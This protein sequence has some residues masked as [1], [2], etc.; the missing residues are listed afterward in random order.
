M[1]RILPCGVFLQDLRRQLIQLPEFFADLQL[2]ADALSGGSAQLL[3]R[4]CILV[5]KTAKRVSI[6]ENLLR[7][8]AQY[9]VF[10]KSAGKAAV[11][12]FFVGEG[13]RLFET[14]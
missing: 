7:C 5:M 14:A 3:I 4:R 6:S 12:A 10:P 1:L 9:S 11:D 13:Y 8:L 2:F